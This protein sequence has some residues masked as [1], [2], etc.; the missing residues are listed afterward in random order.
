[1]E[2]AAVWVKENERI[3]TFGNYV[4]LDGKNNE[5]QGIRPYHGCYDP[6]SYPIFFPRAELG[7]HSNIPKANIEMEDVIKARANRIDHANLGL[8]F[9]Y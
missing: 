1:L 7:W 8:H 6:L 5:I 9:I 3:N 2:V 4:I